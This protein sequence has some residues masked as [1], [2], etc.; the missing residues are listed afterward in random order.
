MCP[1]E[2]FKG[3][4]LFEEDRKKPKNQKHVTFSLRKNK[5]FK[6]LKLKNNFKGINHKK[7]FTLDS[8]GDLI[9]MQMIEKN[10]KN[11]KSLNCL[12]TIKEIQKKWK[13]A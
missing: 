10:F 12:K 9:K 8:F 1:G 4:V 6:I 7:Y 5:K 13:F 11:L 2:I 3:K